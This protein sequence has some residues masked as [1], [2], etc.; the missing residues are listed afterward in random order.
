MNKKKWFFLSF[1]VWTLW[2]GLS[3]FF[4]KTS[5]FKGFLKQAL[6][7]V[8]S[9]QKKVN[10]DFA[11]VSLNF[12]PPGLTFRQVVLHQEAFSL[13][14]QGLTLSFSFLQSLF[15]GLTLDVLHLHQAKVTLIFDKERAA[16]KAKP[17]PEWKV[18]QAF[19]LRQLVVED[20]TIEGYLKDQKSFHLHLM[21][22]KSEKKDLGFFLNLKNLEAHFFDLAS[23][24]PQKISLRQY[25]GFLYP[26]G[27]DVQSIELVHNFFRA[28]WSG[29]IKG[30]IFHPMDWLI[31]GQGDL[32][33]NLQFFYKIFEKY[34]PFP[35]PSGTFLYR[36]SVQVD[37]E[38]WPHHFSIEGKAE[39]D[40]PRFREWK[41]DRLELAGKVRVLPQKVSCALETFKI[42]SVP[43]DRLGHFGEGGTLVIPPFK[44]S[45]PHWDAFLKQDLASEIELLDVHPHWLFKPWAKKIYGLDTRLSGKIHWKWMPAEK[46]VQADIQLKLPSFLWDNQRDQKKIK[47]KNLFSFSSPMNLKAHLSWHPQKG[48]VMED[49]ELRLPR[50]HLSWSGKIQS[51]FSLKAIGAI[52]LDDFQTIAEQPVSGKGS[53]QL[54]IEKKHHADLLV[55]IFPKLTD[56]TYLNLA[57]GALTGELVWD[58]ARNQLTFNQWALQKNQLRYALSG[59][60]CFPPDQ[61]NSLHLKIDWTKG[62]VGDFHRIFEHWIEKIPQY[63]KKLQGLLEGHAEVTGGLD[64]KD[65]SI[66]SQMTGERWTYWNEGFKKVAFQAGLKKGGYFFIEPF[67][68]W[69]NIVEGP[70]VFQASLL[71][72]L[73]EERFE[74][75]VHSKKIPFSQWNYFSK[76]GFP[77]QGDLSFETSG[78]LS[79]EKNEHQGKLIFSDTLIQGLAYDS[80]IFHWNRVKHFFEW[81]AD[82][83]SHQ[84]MLS[85]TEEKKDKGV[86]KS[87]EGNLSQFDLRPFLL[88]INARNLINPLK[89]NLSGDWQF[90]WMDH[91]WEKFSGFFS[92]KK[93][94]IS[95]PTYFLKLNEPLQTEI[96]GGNFQFP[97]IRLDD[98]HGTLLGSL[99]NT[100]G[101]LKAQLKG[102]LDPE[103]IHFL[104]PGVTQLHGKTKIQLILDGLIK[105]PEF[106]AKLWLQGVD[107][108]L[109]FLDSPVEQIHGLF[110]WKNR[111]LYVPSLEGILGG[112]KA[113]MNGFLDF[114]PGWDK[115][116]MKL[117]LDLDSAQI[118]LYPFDRL[119]L[120]A[121][122]SL[123]GEQV[124]YWIKG[125]VT[126]ESGSSYEKLFQK[127][128]KKIQ[129]YF[130][131]YAPVVVQQKE[132]LDQ[133]FQLQVRAET[134]EG[135]LL[136]ENELFKDTTLKAQLDL[137]QAPRN[138]Q[139]FGQVSFVKGTLLFKE[140]EFVI[141]SGSVKMD[142][143]LVQEAS[144]DLTAY[145]DINAYK[146]KL[147]ASGKLNHMKI[148]LTSSPPL[149][150]TEIISLLTFGTLSAESKKRAGNDLGLLQ[151][152]E[153][154]SLVLYSL[155]FQKELERKTGFQFQ[156]NEG[157]NERQGVS[158][159]R[160]DQSTSSS[161]QISVTKKISDHLSISG[162]TNV[163]SVVNQMNQVSLEY[164]VT[165]SVSITGVLNNYGTSSDSLTNSS[166][167][168]SVSTSGGMDLKFKKGF[169]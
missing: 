15:Q 136:M 26:F 12:F 28:T 25:E 29:K 90:R 58:D 13:V 77:V 6:L 86:D 168:N 43:Q 49:G 139:F 7:Y 95:H 67:S 160:S 85:Y 62:P 106:K 147:F 44:W 91:E 38:H 92:L 75:K 134:K 149:P 141:Q 128:K 121:D 140:K 97:Q 76:L 80:S 102:E 130:L 94:H 98:S 93:F 117:Q 138:P 129:D 48:I 118:R 166:E 82:L 163:G 142:R 154:A 33:G 152:G 65:L 72:A 99:K 109:D 100:E 127:N 27:I 112:G 114:M 169:R 74:W 19:P 111:K 116:L 123:E 125:H 10:V 64:L 50:T 47:S 22:G 113:S 110:S 56:V 70:P 143:P 135:H 124:P 71:Y 46:T 155:E 164:I 131:R 16:Q 120:S 60:L 5:F 55:K 32:T 1:F 51:V 108:Q 122:L 54:I 87:F 148:E 3:F 21:A 79:Q 24:G 59:D 18:L 68:L 35:A 36:G 133:L 84:G 37:L 137:R 103:I 159:F 144:F 153:A 119:K 17:L 157:I 53:V 89:A 81:K 61:E 156:L 146:I 8:A 145:S 63:P 105:D 39:V 31:Q 158:A 11:E 167:S 20:V 165:P 69:K 151:Q 45:A 66:F 132:E 107:L 126:M 115:P 42:S 150:E 14:G 161:P 78:H 73:F 88:L 9:Q 83:F 34:L 96:Q 52:D 104:L 23:F 101:Q 41:A 2:S 162:K 57:L 30:N 40:Q 4:L